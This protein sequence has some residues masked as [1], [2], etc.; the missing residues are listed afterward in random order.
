MKTV[1][2]L[3]MLAL[4]L[5]VAGLALVGCGRVP[6]QL[7]AAA[8][9]PATLTNEAKALVDGWH[10]QSGQL[11]LAA[12]KLN[13][14]VEIDP[15][16]AKAYVQVCRLHIFAEFQYSSV[17]EPHAAGTAEKAILKAIAL[18]P[19]DGY[20]F[21]LKGRLY[22]NMNRIAEAKEALATAEKIGTDSP[23]L[24]LNWADIYEREGDFDRAADI[25]RAVIASGTS[26][27]R[28]LGSAYAELSSYY[29]MRHQWDKADEVHEK[30]VKLDPTNAWVRGNYAAWLANNGQFARAIPHARE[31]LQIMDYGAGR[32]TLATSL[33]G[34][35]ATMLENGE[36]PERARPY[37]DEARS[38][39]PDLPH[40]AYETY[41]Y[42]ASE[43]IAKMLWKQG[44]VTK[45]DIIGP[46]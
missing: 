40:V 16:Y 27:K 45:L 42:P 36:S 12:Q 28:A 30:H 25:Y 23:W 38:I 22:A 41:K 2:M 35:W 4:A 29:V 33:Y 34:Q 7:E 8:E 43:I 5:S 9:D 6:A 3:R 26:D 14:A 24:K 17:F 39:L 44:Y 32:D 13:R 31:A 1:K 37:F 20:A 15:N 10:G 19:T 18:D 11:D 21:V 46:R